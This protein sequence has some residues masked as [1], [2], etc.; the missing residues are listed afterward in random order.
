[1]LRHNHGKLTEPRYDR[2]ELEPFGCARDPAW[3]DNFPTLSPE[4]NH[5]YSRPHFLDTLKGQE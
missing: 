3:E 5:E 4:L 2:A 1:M